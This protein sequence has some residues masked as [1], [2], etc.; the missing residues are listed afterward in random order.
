MLADVKTMKIHLKVIFFLRKL[1]L[2][3]SKVIQ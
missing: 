2:N 3:A 1:K